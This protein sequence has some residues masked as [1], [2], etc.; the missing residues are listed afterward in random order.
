MEEEY[1]KIRKS[2]MVGI[3][4]AIRAKSGN[5]DGIAPANMAALIAAIEAGGGGGGVRIAYEIVTFAEDTFTYV[6]EHNFGAIPHFG[7]FINDYKT[8]KTYTSVS[9]SAFYKAPVMG[10]TKHQFYNS[11][12]GMTAESY[13]T[14][15]AA[16]SKKNLSSA[17]LGTTSAGVGAG[18]ETT[19]SF[20][21]KSNYK[22]NAGDVVFFL[23]GVIDE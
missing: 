17:S 23:A 8:Q 15:S 22:F 19:L 6:M 9:A 2:L 14:P 12:S 10:Y 18:T 4:D 7:F 21:A 16:L 20:G 3:A 5:T 11:I 1:G 13:V